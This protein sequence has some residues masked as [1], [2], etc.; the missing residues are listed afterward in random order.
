MY[1]RRYPKFRNLK[2][3][4][5]YCN[6]VDLPELSQKNG[7]HYVYIRKVDKNG[8][9]LVSTC[10]SLESKTELKFNKVHQIKNGNIYPIPKNDSNFRLW[11]GINKNI[12]KVHLSKIKSIGIHHFKTRHHFMIGKNK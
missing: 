3:K 8:M 5:G 2:G 4:V 6:N 11:T 1:N 7:G 10:T 9:C 12:Q